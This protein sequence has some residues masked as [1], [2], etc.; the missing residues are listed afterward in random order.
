MNYESRYSEYRLMWVIV[1]FDMPTTT[2][3]QRKAYSDFRKKLLVDGFNMFQFSIYVRN[4]PSVENAEVHK[5][6]VR[7]FIPEE[8]NVV[9][10]TITDKQFS[11][12][13]NHQGF[14]RPEPPRKAIQLELF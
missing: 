9:I 12:I 7:A 13:E 1:F 5:K 2:K 10:M 14:I 4:C 6:R 3:V 11:Q 8:G